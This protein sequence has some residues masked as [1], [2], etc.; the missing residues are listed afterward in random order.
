MKRLPIRAFIWLQL[1]ECCACVPIWLIF[2]TFQENWCTIYDL[3]RNRFSF[4]FVKF[5]ANVKYNDSRKKKLQ[6][7]DKQFIRSIWFFLGEIVNCP[8]NSIFTVWC[9][10][11]VFFLSFYLL[12]FKCIFRIGIAVGQWKM[13]V[14]GKHRAHGQFRVAKC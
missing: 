4:S 5:N 13:C 12:L 9:H 1:C 3:N 10:T 7:A 2:V 14:T 11:T 6:E 8:V